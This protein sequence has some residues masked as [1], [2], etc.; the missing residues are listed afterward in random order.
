ML[1]LISILSTTASTTQ[2]ASATSLKSSSIF[3]TLINSALFFSTKS[4][5][6]DFLIL[7][8]AFS[9]IWFLD[10]SFEGKSRSV[11]SILAFAIWAAIPLPIVPDPITTTF[12]IFM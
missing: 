4:G 3:P 5:G 12:L 9:V 10:P 11:T 6:R 2:S 1:C 8:L 7:S